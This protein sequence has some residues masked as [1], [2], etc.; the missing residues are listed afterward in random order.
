MKKYIWISLLFLIGCGSRKVELQK[1]IELNKSQTELYQKSITQL[2]E[3]ISQSEKVEK[4]LT[5]QINT[6]N[7]ELESLRTERN[8]LV[9]KINSESQDDIIINDANGNVKITDSKGNTYEIPSGQGTQIAKTNISKVQQEK[10]SIQETLDKTLEKQIE[11]SK[12]LK[13]KESSIKELNS[14][15][16]K[17]DEEIKK[18]KTDI[19]EKKK[20]IDRTSESKRPSFA[21]YILCLFV[22]VV[23]GILVW[24][25]LKKQNPFNIFKK[26]KS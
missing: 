26:L 21:W 15:I 24:E 3:K 12:S 17:Q 14:I 5:E 13:Q 4:E 25:Y 11:L 20:S 2:D 22:G 10:K 18:L 6:K 16:S 1:Q 7:S 19:L 9:E 23:L 8:E